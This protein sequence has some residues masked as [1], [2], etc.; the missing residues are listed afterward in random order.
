M[1]Y[2]ENFESKIGF[3]EIRTMLKGRCLSA[4]GI[5]C[6]DKMEFLDDNDEIGERLSQISEMRRIMADEDDFPD[7]NFIDVRQSLMRIR[8]EGTF[9][10]N[11]RCSTS[12]AR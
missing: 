10:K 4:L 1:I 6:V 12:N 5:E 11:S 7:E 2:P 9:S 8:L 3:N